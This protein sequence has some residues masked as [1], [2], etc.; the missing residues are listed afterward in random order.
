[1]K[2]IEYAYSK[3]NLHLEVLKKRD[4]GYHDIFSI[5]ANT[6][7]CDL[8]KLDK[9]T[10][11]CSKPFDFKFVQ[12]TGVYADFFKSIPVPNNLITKAA[13]LYCQKAEVSVQI[14]LSLE[15]NIPAGGGLGGGSADAAAMLR[16]LNQELKFFSE[17]QLLEIAA[18]IG[19]DVPFCIKGGLSLCEGVGEQLTSVDVKLPFYV[20]IAN[21]GVH[22]NTKE[23]YAGVCEVIK[24]RDYS[25]EEI[26]SKKTKFSEIL[27]EGVLDDFNSF[28]YNDFEDS[29]FK[30]HNSVFKLKELVKQLG[31]EFVLMTGSGS[32][33]IGL[34][35]NKILADKAVDSLSNK[36]LQVNL[37][38]FVNTCN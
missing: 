23:A 14:E 29:V 16:L 10:V 36:A 19:A 11:D 17:E 34:F 7:L 4:D 32:T 2:K 1:M 26:L 9:L 8:L 22:I 25:K 3:I 37:A 6:S 20:L 33:I 31:A 15:K 5:M 24:G 21:N 30:K 38:T 18:Q 27:T 35:N 13:R 28:F 12:V